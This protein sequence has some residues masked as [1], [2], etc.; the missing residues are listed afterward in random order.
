MSVKNILFVILITFFLNACYSY[1]VFPKEYRNASFN[2]TKRKAYVLNPELKKELKILERAAI[3]DI[4][5]DST[6][7]VKIQLYPL[8]KSWVCGQ[9][10][11]ASMLT[12]GQLPVYLPD[13][14]RYSFDEI[15]ENTTITKQF[16]LTIAKRVWFWDMLTFDK[17]FEKKSG[18][19]LQGM[20]HESAP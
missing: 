3:F 19:A 18:K 8:E 10:L 2:E 7:A 13:R 17:N 4:V 15:Q 9:P 11:T 16:E 1:K 12:L 14:Y 5:E 6:H 20:Y